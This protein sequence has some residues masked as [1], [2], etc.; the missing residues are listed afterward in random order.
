MDTKAPPVHR[1]ALVTGA[2]RGI[3]RATVDIL[4]G[5]G[6]SVVAV[7]SCA[8]EGQNRPAGVGYPLATPEELSSLELAYP[9]RV[10]A[11]RSITRTRAPARHEH[12]SNAAER[13][14]HEEDR[15]QPRT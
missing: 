14:A 15:N 4:Y 3:G 6:Y 7:D 13:A 9:G 1:V 2:A 11:C 8:G 10:G 5:Q 12:R